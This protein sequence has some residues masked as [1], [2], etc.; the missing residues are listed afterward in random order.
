M[1][2]ALIATEAE[3]PAD[4]A[5]SVLVKYCRNR[6]QVFLL[7]AHCL[8]RKYIESERQLETRQFLWGWAWF[9]LPA[10]LSAPR[11]ACVEQRRR[12]RLR[13]ICGS[14]HSPPLCT[15]R[16]RPAPR[17]GCLVVWLLWLH[18]LTSSD[19][20]H[21]LSKQRHKTQ[22]HTR[23][24]RGRCRLWSAV[25]YGYEAPSAL[26]RSKTG[27]GRGTRGASPAMKVPIRAGRGPGRDPPH[28]HPGIKWV[29]PAHLPCNLQC[30]RGANT[31]YLEE[32][33]CLTAGA[34][35]LAAKK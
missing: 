35:W 20:R 8:G 16:P 32:E 11:C 25:G 13:A 12:G 10:E 22:E 3:I 6:S 30:R 24:S 28:P 21:G 27:D 15:P 9:G 23:P 31:C 17:G 19:T 14:R 34:S 2:T 7:D 1:D 5:P 29:Q 4:R 26:I 18:W 33:G